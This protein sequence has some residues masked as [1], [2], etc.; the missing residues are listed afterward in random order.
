MLARAG[1]G[2]GYGLPQAREREV[3]ARLGPGLATSWRERSEQLRAEARSWLSP[4]RRAAIAGA[5]ANIEELGDR[6]GRLHREGDGF[7][8]DRS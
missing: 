8:F 6:L 7:R 5:E 1:V 3:L 2:S 4:G